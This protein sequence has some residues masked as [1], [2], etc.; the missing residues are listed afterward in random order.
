MKKSIGAGTFLTPTPVWLIG[1]YF[2][3]G[4]PNIMTAAWTG[5]CN[6]SKPCAYVSLQKPRATYNNIF[7]T[8]AFTINVPPVDIILE[9]DYVG[10]ISGRK[11]DK[12]EQIKLTPVKSELINAPYIEQCKLIAEC[13]LIKT[14]DLGSHTLFIGEILDVKVDANAFN[15]A[16]KADMKKINPILFGPTEGQ[17]YSVGENLGDAFLTRI[18]DGKLVNMK[19]KNK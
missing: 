19:E 9:T 12:F 13:T 14:L 18:V 17:Y 2:E 10:T 7:K 15:S 8:N 11:I 5:I 3:D 1:A 6:S 16:G 4:T